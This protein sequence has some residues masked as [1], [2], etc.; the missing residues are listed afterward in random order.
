MKRP[1]LPPVPAAPPP[2]S[3]HH[4][5]DLG[6][7]LRMIA[8][9]AYG[10]V[11]RDARLNERSAAAGGSEA[12]PS[13]GGHLIA[14]QFSQDL[15]LRM[16]NSGEL[17]RRVRQIPIDSSSFQFPQI[18]ESSR[19]T[20]SRLGGVQ[21]WW[22]A[23]GQNELPASLQSTGHTMKASFNLST[24]TASKLSCYLTLSN[25]IS[26]DST[27]F[28]S[29]ASYAASEEMLFVLENSVINGTGAGQPQG[30]MQ[31]PALITVAKQSGQGSGTVVSANIS[32]MLSSFWA[33]SYVSPSACW[34]YSQSLLPQLAALTT[35]VGTAG[36]EAR[37][38]SWKTSSD[39][40]DRLCGIC[41]IPSEYCAYAGTPSDLLLIDPAR[42]ILAMRQIRG[43]VSL[44]VA[45]LTDSSSFR[46]VWRIAGQTIDR[47]SVAALNGG[48]PPYVTSPFVCLA[49]R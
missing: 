41:A 38:W 47:S 44:H 4:F 30:V 16:Y 27:A 12:V 36:S 10:N 26:M 32:D 23:E 43:D 39:D 48:S 2:A 6:E 49:Q 21:A 15:V 45:F 18:D 13:D 34:L 29:W 14:P 22:N 37:L 9:A 42:Y 17:F 28:D 33:K 11:G 46:F 20:G 1:N 31:S 3:T 5:N 8:R 24:L 40:F 19:A 35:V 25:E 7:Q